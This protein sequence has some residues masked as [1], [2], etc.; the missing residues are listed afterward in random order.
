VVV[1]AEAERAVTAGERKGGEKGDAGREQGK[2]GDG[3]GGYGKEARDRG[4]GREDLLLPLLPPTTYFPF[5]F[6]LV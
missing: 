6:S 3:C 5:F 1:A 2:E 4:G